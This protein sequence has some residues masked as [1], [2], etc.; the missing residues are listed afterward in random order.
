MDLNILVLDDQ[1]QTLTGPLQKALEPFL[2]GETVPDF[3]NI[4][5]D[6]EVKPA[7]VQLTGLC[8]EPVYV[9]FT[10]NRTSTFDQ[11][12]KE[13][14]SGVF[15]AEYD[16][17]FLDDQWGGGA[18]ETAGQEVLL[19]VVF[20]KI[21]GR[22]G[23]KPLIVL[24]TRHWDQPVRTDKFTE[25]LRTRPYWGSNRIR[26]LGK[27]NTAGL[28]LL[29]QDAV[30][31]IEL[32]D[33]AQRYKQELE[34]ERSIN[35]V[36][37]HSIKFPGS[38]KLTQRAFLGRS[39]RFHELMKA[40]N[41]AA[42]SDDNVLITGPTGAGKELIA[43]FIASNSEKRRD[44]PFVILNC[45]ALPDSLIESELFGHSKGAFTDAKER[46]KGRFEDADGGIIF[47]DEIGD[48]PKNVQ[49]KL[50]RAVEYGEIQTIKG[51][52]KNVD[53]RV[54]CATKENLH[55]LVNEGTFREDLFYRLGI[56]KIDVPR[57]NE[58]REDISLLAEHF[59]AL[60]SK[61]SGRAIQGFTPELLSHIE[62][63]EWPGNVRQLEHSIMSAIANADGEYL[64]IA[65][66]PSD[67]TES[68]G[69]TGSV[70][71][72]S[73]DRSNKLA[74][75]ELHTLRD[76]EA[77]LAGGK[78]YKDIGAGILGA[79]KNPDQKFKNYWLNASTASAF[80][81]LTQKQ[82]EENFPLIVDMLRRRKALHDR[83]PSYISSPGK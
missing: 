67:I 6:M 68:F 18:A 31:E 12:K 60:H 27:S 57:L 52:I 63:Y 10:C 36:L 4:G 42:R 45:A 23:R 50:L 20:D 37:N 8:D 24:W 81:R 38:K 7:T 17:L 54:I 35:K 44:K 59:L 82:A 74:E 9:T 72:R 34:A 25:I 47:L 62:Q 51:P 46:S 69:R 71:R 28:R 55:S 5:P 75:A 29:V 1:L 66:F 61:R 22:R 49:A 30:A 76:I 16:M 43:R 83:Y 58:R 13:I 21:E 64:S 40:V 65:D 3:I 15:D 79:A 77:A 70:A 80:H 48:L 73:S 11:V 78:S 26:G 32:N 14:E 33:T 56:I 19:P 39:Q 2:E 53:V 41:S